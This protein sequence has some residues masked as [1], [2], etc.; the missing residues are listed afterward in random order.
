MAVKDETEGTAHH[1]V[2]KMTFQL[3]LGPCPGDKTARQVKCG[4]VGQ[5]QEKARAARTT[6]AE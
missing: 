5:N 6:K 2:A 1:V 3:T 4:T